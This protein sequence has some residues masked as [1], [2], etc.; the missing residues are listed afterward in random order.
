MRSPVPDLLDAVLEECRDAGDDGELAG[1]IPELADA[2]P[3]RFALALCTV[4]GTRYAVGDAEHRFTIQSISKPF[5]YALALADRGYDEVLDH[6]G[7]EPSGDAFNE[8][9]LEDNGR[10][11]NPMINIGAIT[12]HALAGPRGATA[13]QSTAR[14]L[15]GLSTFAGREL[16][17][18]EAVEASERETADRNLA[19]AYL[20]RAR[21][22]L[23]DEPHDAV[24]G[25][26]R[27]CSALVDVR[28]L[29][30]MAMTLGAGGRNPVTGEQVV[31]AWVCRQVLSVMATCGMYDAAGDWMTTVGIPAKSGVS[32]GVLGALPG[33][34][35]I[36]AFSPRLDRFGNSVRGSRAFE[37]LSTEMGLHLMHAPEVAAHVLY[38]LVEP[39]DDADGL[40]EVRLQGTM[41]FAAAEAALRE[42]EAV[43]DD[44]APVVVD[45]SRVGSANA[46]GRRMLREGVERLR[47]D[48]HEV[49][50]EDPDG[51]LDD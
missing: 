33:Q 46:V 42:L 41:H 49:R 14:V 27:Q 4:D 39:D 17:V 40:R 29:A 28:D 32:G 10:P 2:D 43:P 16:E 24:D 31:P 1:S 37:R 22:K 36:G 44:G 51:V 19:L 11:R 25:Y 48:G 34:V 23:Q 50:V 45:L 26:I 35:G 12:T 6:V 5:V 8:I 20:V 18:D 9:S 21:G 38:G 15:E 13:E 47:R 7:V 30:V 3:E